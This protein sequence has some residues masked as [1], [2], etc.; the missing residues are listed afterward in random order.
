MSTLVLHGVLSW[1]GRRF[2][3]VEARHISLTVVKVVSL[4]R[5]S[6]KVVAQVSTDSQTTDQREYISFLS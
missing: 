1:A 3:S 5:I 2:M 4:Q 6:L